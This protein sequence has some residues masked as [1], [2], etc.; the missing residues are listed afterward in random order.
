VVNTYV[1]AFD[2]LTSV[3]ARTL[4]A[5]VDNLGQ[6][7]YGP[8]QELAVVRR[9][10]LPRR[11]RVVVWVFFEGNDLANIDAYRAFASDFAAARAARHGFVA[12]SFSRNAMERLMY[13]AG[14]P[15][16]SAVPRSAWWIAGG[17]KERLY[18]LYT[19][20]PLSDPAEA[21]LHELESI[22]AQAASMS[23]EAGAHFVLAFAPDKFRACRGS[24][25]VEP[26]A[27]LVG[28]TL[29]DLPGRLAAMSARLPGYVTYLDLTPTLAF[30]C[31]QGELPY[32]RE[33]NHWNAAGNRIVAEEL[34]RTLKPL[35]GEPGPGRPAITPE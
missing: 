16:P 15:R 25:V 10:A 7:G 24:L 26:D 33:D 31:D 6:I 5:T 8:Q 32:F 14:N 20:G 3:L 23:H 35:L 11:P 1:P 18:F 2:L 19:A 4:G 13:L 21:A 9:Y 27:D 12:R 30:H 22:L 17:R 29:S 34:A 28:W